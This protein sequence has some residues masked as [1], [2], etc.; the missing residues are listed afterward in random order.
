[1]K[2]LS[3]YI[4]SQMAGFP[5]RLNNIFL[6]VHTTLSLSTRLKT[7]IWAAPVSRLLSMLLRWTCE[8]RY[9]FEVLISGPLD[10]ESGMELLDHM[11]VLCLLFWGTSVLFVVIF[12]S[13]DNSHPNRCELI[14]IFLKINNVGHLFTCLAAICLSSLEKFWLFSSSVL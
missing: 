10:I 7:D 5:L 1:M 6:Y 2:H 12:Y 13:L 3:R 9:I 4:L 11:V 14:C 8:C